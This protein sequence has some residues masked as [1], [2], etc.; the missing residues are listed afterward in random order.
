[1][2]KPSC[3]SDILCK[4]VDDI[5]PLIALIQYSSNR[6][7]SAFSGLLLADGF[8]EAGY[9]THV[10]FGHSGPMLEEYRA[11]GHGVGVQAH[12]SW[13]RHS[14]LFRFGRDVFHEW[15]ASSEFQKEIESLAPTL[16]YLN[17]SVSLTAALAARRTG[18]PMVWHLRELFADVGGEMRVPALLKPFVR[19]TFVR[20]AAR[21]VVPSRAIAK[22]M[23]G[24]Y[25]VQ[26]DVVPNA[27]ST[28]FFHNRTSRVTASEKFELPTEAVVV[29]LPGMIRPMKGHS[30]FLKAMAPLL[31]ERSEVLL[32][33][34]GTGKERYLDQLRSEVD[35]LGI[36]DRVRFLGVVEDMPAFYR[37]CDVT[38]V[39]SRSEPFGRTIIESMASRTPVVASRVGGIPEIIR[40]GETGLLFEYGHGEELVGHVRR[41]LDHPDEAAA[42]S[43]RAFRAAQEHYHESVYKQ[44]IV[45]IVR[46]VLDG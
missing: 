2:Q 39:P 8:R 34:T 13:L 40:H 19:R 21:I 42:L 29:G 11:H 31:K 44:R 43:E 46:Q 36:T 32:A 1:M 26:A 33:V 37:S 20:R 3:Q 9:R 24:R 4:T 10:L 15:E 38:V 28:T 23:L 5:A 18:I 6:D 17:T 14:H 25:A 45:D 30:F 35:A 41:L 16:V 27:A 22:N 12:A 7:G